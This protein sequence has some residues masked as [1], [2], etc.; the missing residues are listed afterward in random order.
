MSSSWLVTTPSRC[1][2][3]P[4]SWEK[5]FASNV[6]CQGLYRAWNP[7]NFKVNQ[8]WLW[9][10]NLKFGSKRSHRRK[11]HINKMS[12]RLW[13]FCLCVS[14]LHSAWPQKKHKQT[15]ATH[16]VP[17]QSLQICLCLCV[18]PWKDKKL[19]KWAWHNALSLYSA[20]LIAH[21]LLVK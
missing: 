17:G 19:T 21:A 20:P 9:G 6:R 15:F 16:P 4:T 11:K 2:R 13:G 18:F 1:A 8:K 10:S 14:L 3:L 5:P 12:T 7:E